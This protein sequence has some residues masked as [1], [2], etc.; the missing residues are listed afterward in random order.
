GGRGARDAGRA[1]SPARERAAGPRPDGGRSRAGRRAAQPLGR[2]PE[3]AGPA[4]R[5]RGG[6]APHGVGARGA[7]SASRVPG[8]VEAPVTHILYLYG[9]VPAESA[10]P[11]EA[12]AGVDGRPVRLL[13]AG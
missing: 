6:R 7:R 3:R 5:A 10:A 1:A 2:G 9:F 11:P 13:D 8:R 12:L 4:G